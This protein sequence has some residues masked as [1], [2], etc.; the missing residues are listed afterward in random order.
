MGGSCCYSS[1]G[2]EIADVPGDEQPHCSHYEVYTPANAEETCSFSGAVCAS[3]IGCVQSLPSCSTACACERDEDASR[4]LTLTI[5]RSAERLGLP[6]P[7]LTDKQRYSSFVKS[8]EL[9][10]KTMG[11]VVGCFIGMFP[12]LFMPE[13]KSQLVDQISEKLPPSVRAEFAR[14]VTRKCYQEGEYLLKYGEMSH[15]VMLLEGGEVDCVGRDAHGLPFQVCTMGSGHSF[16]KPQLHFP[17]RVDL[18]AKDGEVVVQCIEKDEFC[19]LTGS[20]GMEVWQETQNEAHAVYLATFG[21]DIADAV[22]EAK[23]GTGKT[24]QFASLADDEKLEVLAFT[25]S[26]EALEFTGKPNEGKVRFFSGLPEDVKHDALEQFHKQKIGLH[27][28]HR[29]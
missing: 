16:G 6:D 10:S 9:A 18:I 4:T 12:L 7:K 11:I 21:K 15:F 1:C 27:V 14:S 25:G 24:R 23:K 29:H 8:F 17:S 28:L 2:D 19:R 26:P 5:E 3:S 13:K 20:V 22:P